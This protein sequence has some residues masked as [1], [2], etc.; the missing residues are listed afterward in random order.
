ME[1]AVAQFE[2]A[3]PFARTV[4]HRSFFE[5]LTRLLLRASAWSII[6]VTAVIF[7]C[8]I[9]KG[10]PVVF[11]N[12]SFL[13]KLPETLHVIEDK[14]GHVQETNASGAAAIKQQLG[15]NF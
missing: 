9:A 1:A 3:N 2:M 10:A 15:E 14:Q 7:A 13:T 4:S 11:A 5:G 8:I 6:A 12:P